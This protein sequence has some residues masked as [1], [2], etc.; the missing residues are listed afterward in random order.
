MNK[1]VMRHYPAANLPD[2]LRNGLDAAQEVTI[3]IETEER[4][5]PKRATTIAEIFISR[6]PPFRTKEQI[7]EDLRRD[8]EEWDG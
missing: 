2:D 1:I 3:T 7:D 8:R 6:R 4:D 5:Q